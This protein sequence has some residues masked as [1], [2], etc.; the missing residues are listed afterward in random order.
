M[1][2]GRAMTRQRWTR[3]EVFKTARK[4]SIAQIKSKC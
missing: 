3:A 2:K 4:M 1:D